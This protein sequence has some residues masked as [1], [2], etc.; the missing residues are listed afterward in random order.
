[1]PLESGPGGR[2]VV[3]RATHGGNPTFLPPQPCTNRIGSYASTTAYAAWLSHGSP[4][5]LSAAESERCVDVGEN[6]VPGFA[7]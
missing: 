1:M 3:P 4:A 7:R 6:S 2:C 5:S